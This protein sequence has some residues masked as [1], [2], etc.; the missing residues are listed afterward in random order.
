VHLGSLSHAHGAPKKRIIGKVCLTCF[1]YR[2]DGEKNNG[3]SFVLAASQH[4]CGNYCLKGSWRWNGKI[5]DTR[6]LAGIEDKDCEVRFSA[7]QFYHP[8]NYQWVQNSIGHK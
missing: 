6:A 4:S 3:E 5:Q 2:R 8:S 1:S 7:S